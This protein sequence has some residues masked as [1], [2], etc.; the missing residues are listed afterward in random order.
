MRGELRMRC[1]A[2]AWR[3]A[4]GSCPSGAGAERVPPEMVGGDDLD[5]RNAVSAQT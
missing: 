3:K 4:G 5:D 2:G 1:R